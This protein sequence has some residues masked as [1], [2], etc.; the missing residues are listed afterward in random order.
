MAGARIDLHP[1]IKFARD[2]LMWEFFLESAGDG[3]PTLIFNGD[4]I[5]R[6]THQLELQKFSSRENRHDLHHYD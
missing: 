5:D 4:W 1:P 3:R 2:T 6:G